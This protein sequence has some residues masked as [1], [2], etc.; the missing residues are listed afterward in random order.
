MIWAWDIDTN[1][2]TFAARFHQ[3]A[4]DAGV[5]LRP[6]GNSLYFMPPYVLAET[7]MRHLV[8]CT[9]RTL[10][11]VLAQTPA[12]ASSAATAERLA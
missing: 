5:L 4:L 1:D 7:D 6:I 9:L 12:A 11:Q 10:D 3:L 2:A 8:D